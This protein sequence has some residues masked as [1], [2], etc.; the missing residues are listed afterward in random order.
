[1]MKHISLAFFLFINSLLFGQDVTIKGSGAVASNNKVYACFTTDALTQNL[2]IVAQTTANAQ[3]EFEL[4]IPIKQ[5]E[6]LFLCTSNAQTS[7]WVNPKQT[8][9]VE[10][11]SV[12]TTLTQNGL[13]RSWEAKIDNTSSDRTNAIVGE[14]NSAIAEFLSDNSFNYML[15]N[16]QQ[17]KAATSRMQEI[18]PKSDLVKFNS[19]NDSS[20]FAA[21]NVNFQTQIEAFE[22]KMNLKFGDYFKKDPFLLNYF[23]FEIAS[24]RALTNYP[25]ALEKISSHIDIKN[26]AFVKWLELVSS[27]Y[28]NPSLNTRDAQAFT[29]LL[30]TATSSAPIIHYLNPDSTHYPQV[31]ELILISALRKNYY[32]RAHSPALMKKLLGILQSTSKFETTKSLAKACE[33]EFSGLKKNSLLPDITLINSNNDKWKFT[34]HCDRNMYLY[35]FNESKSSQRD[36]ALLN[37]LASKYKNDFRIVVIGMHDNFESFQKTI[38]PFKLDGIEVLYGGNDFKLIQELRIATVP[39]ALQTNFKGVLQFEYTPLPAEGIQ[40]K[41]EEIIR[42]SKK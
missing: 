32:T 36:L 17:N 22:N 33:I 37:H 11:L 8:Y 21:A 42:K 34:E 16:S 38:A 19:K 28:L 6:N 31:E 7:L 15:L 13:I 12:D 30:E 2:N 26:P 5:R 10:F 25:V 18:N 4:K 14:I 39:C 35:F 41:W 29:L 23:F 24:L 9:A 27:N 40:Q 20:E 3:G 1:M